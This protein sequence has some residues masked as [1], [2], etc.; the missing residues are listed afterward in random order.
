MKVSE[1]QREKGR[2]GPSPE[3][4]TAQVVVNAGSGGAIQ[5]GPEE[6]ER[7][8]VERF[9]ANGWRVQ[10]RMAPAP[11]VSA[12]LRDAIAADPP[13]LI[14]GGGDGT[15]LSAVSMLAG[16][17]IPL[18]ILPLGTFN[19]LARDLGTPAGW[20][21]AVDFVTHCP[22]RDIDVGFVNGRPFLSL[23]V[24]G[25]FAGPA[26]AP[27]GGA[28]WWVKGL[29]ILWASMSSYLDYPALSLEVET[30]QKTSHHRTRL[31]GISNNL[32]RDEAGLIVP[33]R[34]SLDGGV[35]GVYVSKHASRWAVMRG[36]LAYLAGRMRDDPDLLIETG[37]SVTIRARFRKS[38][39]LS[40]DGETLREALPLRFCL[41]PRALRVLGAGDPAGG[42]GKWKEP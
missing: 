38:L 28:P 27:G 13:V 22:V 33:Q 23:C 5:S 36:G 35:L 3:S 15:V 39:R 16:R 42:A 37:R 7:Q 11:R 25:F 24:L 31:V 4:W 9:A 40:L 41:K 21:A 18:G 29:R 32:L 1:G 17:R 14:V 8:L 19:T 34:N 30:G 2:V 10:M 26:A 20:E 12:A 6:W